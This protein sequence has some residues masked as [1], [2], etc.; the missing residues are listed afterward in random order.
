S[1]EYE[2]AFSAS[3]YSRDSEQSPVFETCGDISDLAVTAEEEGCMLLIEWQQASE[4][5]RHPAHPSALRNGRMSSTR[6]CSSCWWRMRPP[7][8]S[9]SYPSGLGGG[10]RKTASINPL[11]IGRA[12]TK[13]V[14]R[15]VPQ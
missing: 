11:A 4:W 3:G 14:P 1:G 10:A 5:V 7:P 12:C 15:A 13:R 6:N 9:C 8:K 2:R